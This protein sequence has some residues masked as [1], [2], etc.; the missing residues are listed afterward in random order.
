[1]EVT[2]VDLLHPFLL[3]PSENFLFCYSFIDILLLKISVKHIET[4][5]H[6]TYMSEKLIKNIAIDIICITTI[7]GLMNNPYVALS[8]RPCALIPM[9]T[10][11][12]GGGVSLLA[13]SKYLL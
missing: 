13:I 6:K 10:T 3:R 2:L 5:S 4:F 7:W 9:A 1:M 12:I 8:D 11:I